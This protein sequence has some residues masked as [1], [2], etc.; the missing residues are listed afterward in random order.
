MEL[1]SIEQLTL[2]EMLEILPHVDEIISWA[3]GIKEYCLEEA[4]KGTPMPGW[5]IVHGKSI[6]KWINESMVIDELKKTSHLTEDDVLEKKLLSPSKLEK[7]VGKVYF[8]ARLSQLVDKPIG[9]PTLVKDSEERKEFSQKLTD[10]E[11]NKIF[12]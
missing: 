6:R 1:K 5:K 2:E 8:E 11:L 10:E 9:S 3:K 12:K 4:L 7:I